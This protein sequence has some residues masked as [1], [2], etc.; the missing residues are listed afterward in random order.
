MGVG[1]TFTATDMASGVM[2]RLSMSMDNLGKHA[3]KLKEKYEQVKK[4][5]K[6]GALTA[7][8]GAGGIALITKTAKA[9]GDFERVVTTASMKMEG[10]A[11]AYDDLRKAAIKGGIETQWSPQEAAGGLQELAAQGL[12]A[13]QA[14]KALRPV[15]DLAI[16]S[17]GELGVA[18]AAYVAT[19]AMNAFGMQAEDLP[20]IVDKLVTIADKSALH[21]NDMATMIGQAA[22]QGYTANQSFSSM[23]TTLGMLRNAGID[24]SSAATA[25]RE[26]MRRLAGD[27]QAVKAMQA[28]GLSAMDAETG[29]VKDL[30][31]IMQ[32]MIPVVEKM[33]DRKKA[34]FLHDVMGV[35]GMKVYSAFLSSYNQGVQAGT[36]QMGNYR[37]AFDNLFKLVEGSTGSTSKKVD[38]VNRTLGGQFTLLSGSWST[39]V[40]QVGS[41][42]AKYVAPVVKWLWDHLNKAIEG[43]NNMSPA[44]KKA[45]GGFIAFGSVMLVF[46]GTLKIVVGFWKLLTL[47]GLIGKY[48]AAQKAAAAATAASTAAT[49]A[50]SAAQATMGSRLAALAGRAGP[51]M[52]LAG[53]GM[54]LGNYLGERLGNALYGSTIRQAEA[55]TKASELRN[56]LWTLSRQVESSG[57]RFSTFN[58]KLRQ[59]TQEIVDK[60]SQSAKAGEAVLQQVTQKQGL[61]LQERRKAFMEASIAMTRGQKDT[62]TAQLKLAFEADQKLRMLEEARVKIRAAQ[63]RR[64]YNNTA[65][66]TQRKH[67]AQMIVLADT[68]ALQE[69]EAK[70]EKWRKTAT[71]GLAA[72]K[73]DKERAAQKLIVEEEWQKRVA[74]M[75][76]KRTKLVRTAEQYGVVRPVGRFV[77][78]TDVARTLQTVRGFMPG[79]M[80]G[81]RGG[82]GGGQFSISPTMMAA[83]MKG[84]PDMM[85]ALPGRERG[86]TVISPEYAQQ[87]VEMRK[88][89]AI[90][91]GRSEFVAARDAGVLED[92]LV[93]EG[94]RRARAAVSSDPSPENRRMLERWQQYA[95]APIDVNVILK[96]DKMAEGLADLESK[97]DVRSGRRLRVTTRKAGTGG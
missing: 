35:R 60:G 38:A 9:Y 45:V 84:V 50:Q 90:G 25:Y 93:K 1:F 22:S 40:I 12:N 39:F 48:V 92:A 86:T 14:M 67:M 72:I 85:R 62:M 20:T 30:A 63:Y 41:L 28:L 83:A 73:D 87:M 77:G 53:V 43:I 8:A 71:S 15:L 69:T 81:G 34:A 65:D 46:G 29:K 11:K 19:S 42:F 57:D 79:W 32:D 3:D 31:A 82:A 47:G 27:K 55:A 24:A 80:L 66:L 61:L 5:M 4:G 51:Y 10:G 54:M 16:S 59:F 96:T 37:G 78:E 13:Q 75:R 7:A 70:H 94:L 76:A 6:A 44:V 52:A 89:A 21:F 33:N 18:Q 88:M 91:A 36:I 26:S 56:R 97:T 2:G 68:M 49:A 23:V 95:N 74:E 58:Q 17:T 64:D